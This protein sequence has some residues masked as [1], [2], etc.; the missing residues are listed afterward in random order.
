MFFLAFLPQFVDPARGPAGLQTLAL[1]LFFNV[2]RHAGERGGGVARRIGADAARVARRPRLVS[3]GERRDSHRAG[4]AARARAMNA[5]IS[6]AGRAPLV[7]RDLLAALEDRE[8]RDRADA[9]AL[10]EVRQLVGVH[11]HDEQ[12]GRP[13][14]PRLSAAPARPCGTART[15]A[16]SSRRRPEATTAR[17][18]RSK[19]ADAA[20]SIGAAGARRSRSC[21]GRTARCRQA[22]RRRAGSSCR[23]PA[24]VD[25]DAAIIELYAF[26]PWV[27]PSASARVLLF[28]CRR[29]RRFR[30]RRRLVRCNRI[31]KQRHADRVG[32]RA[33][34]L[35]Q[36]VVVGV[37]EEVPRRAGHQRRPSASLVGQRACRWAAGRRAPASRVSGS[38][39]VMLRVAW[40]LPSRGATSRAIVLRGLRRRP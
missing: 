21:T 6:G 35:E 13:G 19:S 20:T 7:A 27:P 1:G 12:P 2:V 16:P 34:V 26:L 15:T 5:S 32:M 3:A 28:R 18:A 30:R 29:F 14:A 17:S 11:L 10:A 24:H 37:D 38:A 40:Q 25:D 22:A 36:R 8:R 4:T 23:T 31:A 9:E 33:V 39:T